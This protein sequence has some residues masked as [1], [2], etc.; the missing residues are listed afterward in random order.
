MSMTWNQFKEHIDKQLKI[1]GID[2]DTQIG[3]I[4]VNH[5]CAEQIGVDDGGMDCPAVNFI[6]STLRIS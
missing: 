4:D 2:P 5:P 6:D 3:W 1:K